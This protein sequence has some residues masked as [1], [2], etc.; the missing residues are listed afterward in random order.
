[1]ANLSS[2]LRGCQ[3]KWDYRSP[4]SVYP[5]VDDIKILLNLQSS[6]MNTTERLNKK[7]V[8]KKEEANVMV[9]TPIQFG[10][11]FGFRGFN[12]LDELHSDHLSDHLDGIKIFEAARQATLAAFHLAGMSYDTSVALMKSQLEYVKYVETTIPY[13]IEILPVCRPDGG[14][15]YAVFS[16][17]QNNEIVT[18]GYFDAYTFRSKQQFVDK[19]KK[20]K[21]E[22]KKFA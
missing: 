16:L 5:L 8:H 22:A 7:L 17:I 1:M 14:A 10:N 13:F 9:S 6:L 12:D 21:E 18:K 15:M 3:Y 2:F 20:M 19:R 4:E 11:F